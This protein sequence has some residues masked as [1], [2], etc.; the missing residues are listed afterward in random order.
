MSVTLALAPFFPRPATKLS[1]GAA[2]RTLG[3]VAIVA[4]VVPYVFLNLL[5][6]EPFVRYAAGLVLAH[7]AL[8]ILV[9]A[10]LPRVPARG[11]ALSLRCRSILR[12]G[13][14]TVTVVLGAVLVAMLLAVLLHRGRPIDWIW[15]GLYA[16]ASALAQE[17]YFRGWL[18][19]A[20]DELWP[21]AP[22]MAV[23]LQAG[24]FALWHVR[25]FLEAAGVMAMLF[26]AGTFVAGL[27]WGLLVRRQGSL[28]SSIVTH[29]LALA[30]WDA[31]LLLQGQPIH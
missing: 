29:T 28:A 16:P 25:A 13:F 5:A 4:L 15:V 9:W 14:T 26:V 17:L 24:L 2:R 20:L 27:M 10:G 19:A 18:L 6:L 8:G 1:P 12:A 7:A 23:A 31:L 21:D 3:A 11:R 22:D 30:G